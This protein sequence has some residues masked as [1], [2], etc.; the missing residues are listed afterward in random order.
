MTPRVL[1]DSERDELIKTLAAAFDEDPLFVWFLPEKEQRRK[2]LGWFH[3]RVLNETM[4]LDGALTFGPSEGALLLY[5]PG[6]WPP[7]FMTGLRAWPIFP[8]LPTWKLMTPG[9]WIDNRIHQLHPNEPH[10]YIYVLGVHPERQGQ[11]L[12]GKLLRHANTIADA[13]RVP[14]HLETAKPSNVELYERFGYLVT[15]EVTEHGGPTI[16][17]MTRPAR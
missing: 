6:K 8:G 4:P 1:L 16:W 12:G 7:T 15:N 10:L 11:G 5:P 17:I 13:A 3:R 14:C 9:L 2:W